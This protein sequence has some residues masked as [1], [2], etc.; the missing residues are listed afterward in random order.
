MAVR[1]PPGDAADAEGW[2]RALLSDLAGWPDFAA[3]LLEAVRGVQSGR[4]AEWSMRYNAYGVEVR[5]T[6]ARVTF[7]DDSCPVP[8]DLLATVLTKHLRL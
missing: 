5:P 8:L 4:V 6:G 1:F 3:E 2:A 7:L